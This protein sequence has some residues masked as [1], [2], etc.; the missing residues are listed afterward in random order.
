MEYYWKRA[1]HWFKESFDVSPPLGLKVP[2]LFGMEKE[3]P[4]D[5]LNIFYRSVRY[6][7]YRNRKYATG[8]SIEAL[9]ELLVDEFD[10][11][12]GRQKWKKYEEHPA[13]FLAIAWL[14]MKKGWNH[15][16]PRWLP[17]I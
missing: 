1:A 3:K 8:P 12:Y 14:R 4:N 10:R 2:R 17:P 15:I 11:K 9:E 16:N 5:L 6:C 13:E 7:I